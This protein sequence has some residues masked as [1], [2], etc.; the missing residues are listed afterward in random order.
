[1]N[2]PENILIHEATV[3]DAVAIVHLI[4]Q[5]GEDSEITVDY[6]YQYLSGADRCI[7]LAQHGDVAAG[8]LSYSVRADLF[9]AGN[10]VLIEEL[11]VDAE[12]R[13]KG[14]GGAL[15][16][17]LMKR[18]Q[19]LHCKEVCLAVMPDNEDAIRFYKR[20]GLTD[21]ALFLERHFIP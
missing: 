10:S 16:E 18:A 4:H 6:V 3:Q 11:V 9:H 21:E 20:Y 1:M 2:T 14:I 17:E 7:L 12:Y 15:L 8:L 5:L 13:G 19:G